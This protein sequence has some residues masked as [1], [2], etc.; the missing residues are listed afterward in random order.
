MISVSPVVPGK[1]NN[2]RHCP[3]SKA[4]AAVGDAGEDQVSP[5]FQGR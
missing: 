2:R 3:S 1:S 4:F 5:R